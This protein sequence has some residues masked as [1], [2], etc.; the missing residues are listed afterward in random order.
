[1]VFSPVS[2][3]AGLHIGVSKL[4]ITFDLEYWR[5]IGFVPASRASAGL[6]ST[7]HGHPG[8]HVKL[9]EELIGTCEIETH[10]YGLLS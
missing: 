2:P 4:P 9:H 8:F 7:G 3:L 5:A 1:M 10:L 6:E